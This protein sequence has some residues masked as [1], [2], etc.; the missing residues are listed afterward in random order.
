MNYPEMTAAEQH[1]IRGGD[2]PGR[3]S[4]VGLSWNIIPSPG[5]LFQRLG[6]PTGIVVDFFPCNLL[7][8][9]PA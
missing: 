7:L 2:I 3:Q 5:I 9:F 6:I 4:E 1:H 8:R